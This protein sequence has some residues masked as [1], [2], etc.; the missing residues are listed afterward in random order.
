MFKMDEKIIKVREY[1]E[2]THSPLDFKYHILSVVKNAALLAEKLNADKEV[3]EIAS[4][5]HDIGRATNWEELD[6][7]GLPSE[8]SKGE[9]KKAISDV[10]HIVG[11][12]KT[13]KILSDIGYDNE[14]IKKV[15]NCILSHRGSKG[16]EP[17][18]VEEKIIA[19][20][21]AM[22]H[23]DIFPLL[24]IVFSKSAGTFEELIDSIER[25][26]QRGWEKK[27]MP[28]A[29]EIVREKYEAIMLIIKSIK[30]QK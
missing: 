2:K 30:E 18:T 20:A 25:K 26:M 10:H 16:P 24:L 9:N 5:L 22:S 4:Y 14:F 8:K 27:L 6:H 17:E 3:V 11:A 23:Y 28:D 29:K 1:A 12:E 7:L 19:S 15:E 13:K 21:D